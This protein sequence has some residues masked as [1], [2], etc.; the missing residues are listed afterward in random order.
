MFILTRSHCSS[1]RWCL[2]VGGMLLSLS[3]LA[4]GVSLPWSSSPSPTPTKFI[5]IAVTVAVPA[6]HPPH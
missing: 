5:E 6:H 4:C 2:I 3:G 1:K